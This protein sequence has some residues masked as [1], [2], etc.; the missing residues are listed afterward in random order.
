[1]DKN[2]T[3]PWIYGP[4]DDGV[5]VKCERWWSVGMMEVLFQALQSCFWCV[6]QEESVL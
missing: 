1:M 2:F 5:G 3:L 6:S 4:L